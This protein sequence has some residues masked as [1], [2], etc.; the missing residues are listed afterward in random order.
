MT[1]QE[2]FDT[3]VNG[4]RKQG[5]KSVDPDLPKHCLC[6][7][8]GGL[9]CA[10]GFLIDDADYIPNMEGNIRDEPLKTYLE[11]KGYDLALLNRLQLVHDRTLVS[12]WEDGF[13][14]IAKDFSLIYR[15]AA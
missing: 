3:A 5:C 10:V 14:E 15:E 4:L 1:K 12:L 11:S 7:G 6:R 9:K 13:K 2:T 8:P